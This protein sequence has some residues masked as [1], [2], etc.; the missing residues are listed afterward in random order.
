M[1]AL[2]T[3]KKIFNAQLELV[4]SEPGVYLMRDKSGSVLYVGKANSLRQRLA[5]YFT[6]NPDVDDRIASMISR[7]ASYD[8]IIC[9]NELEAFILEANL[10]K[11]YRPRYNILMR[12]DKEYPYIHVTLQEEFPRVMRAFRVGE[13]IEEGARYFGPWLSGDV[14][15]ALQA[16]G[17]IFPLRRC[18]RDLPREIGK[19][20]PCLNAHIGRCLAPC[21]G[22]ISKE[23]YRQIVDEV[24]LFLE[25]R[26][27]DLIK[28][29]HSEMLAASDR[30]D[31]EEATVLRGKWQALN[32]LREQQRV[33]DVAGGDRDILALHRNGYEVAIAKLE[34]RDGRVTG[35]VH[36]FAEDSGG[37][38]GTYFSSFIRDH[39]RVSSQIPPE[40]L[41]SALPDEVELL[42]LF[43]REK[44][45]HSVTIRRP[46]RGSKKALLE[47]AMTNADRALTRRAL[48]RGSDPHVL[49]QTLML[50]GRLVGL[51]RLPFRIEAYDVSHHGKGAR[52]GSMVVFQQ[53]KPERGSYRHFSIKGFE[54][55]D[56][57]K[58]LKEIVSRRLDRLDEES[59]GNRPDLILVDGGIGHVAAVLPLVERHGLFVAGMVKDDRHRTRGLVLSSGNIVELATAGSLCQYLSEEERGEC[60]DDRGECEDDRQ[61]ET[62]D[63]RA[64]RLGL[65]HLLTSIQDEAHRF[66]LR[67]NRKVL[68]KRAMRYALEAIPGVGPARRKRLLEHFGTSKK[69][70]EASLEELMSVKGIPHTVAEA[71]YNHFQEQTRR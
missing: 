42:T 60:E 13:D 22:R 28:K 39:Y 41:V 2:Q 44:R 52:S 53:G 5:N 25:G 32:R 20:R 33:V 31:F 59:F 40:I 70:S 35:C 16:L 8:T 10:I 48:S 57:Y 71:V 1:T 64:K 38:D 43:L 23:E 30:L 6:A 50:L 66:A 67:H 29:L 21:A 55:I 26:T 17:S 4:P 34:V 7:I 63:A 62:E 3:N 54:G 65:L 36:T 51:D 15:R 47:L 9:D 58:A 69:I 24:C 14:N 19:E 18:K 11:K 68:E 61:R 49:E 46:Q 56:D 12:D 45:G 37:H 27:D